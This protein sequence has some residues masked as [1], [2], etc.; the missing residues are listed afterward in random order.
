MGRGVTPYPIDNL[1]H[2]DARHFSG[3]GILHALKNHSDTFDLPFSR[4]LLR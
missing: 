4:F 3:G 2:C 1:S